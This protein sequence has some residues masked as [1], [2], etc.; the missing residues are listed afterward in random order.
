MGLTRIVEKIKYPR[1]FL[2]AVSIILA[3]AL[4]QL[5]FFEALAFRLNHHGYLSLLIGGMFFSFGFTA[6]FAVALF[7]ELSNSVNPLIGAPLAGLGAFM[8]DYIIFRFVR[9]SFHDEFELLK[10]SWLFQKVKRL[11]DHHLSEAVKK[12]TLWTFAG[13]LIASPLPDEFGV[14][15]LS[16]LT[17]IN[18]KVFAVISFMLNTTGIFVILMLPRLF[19]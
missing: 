13:L 10:L 12:Y 3:Y 17:D 2:L 1:L 4:F 5:D 15:V 7:I 6:A 18:Q 8:S 14:T 11:F 9:L 19:G 16:G